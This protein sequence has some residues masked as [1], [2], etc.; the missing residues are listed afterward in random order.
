MR[1]RFLFDQANIS[2]AI[3]IETDGILCERMP[4]FEPE[5]LRS[6]IRISWGDVET[7]CL[8]SGQRYFTLRYFTYSTMFC[9]SSE[10][11]LW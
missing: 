4:S 5:T 11:L 9:G 3:G 7:F 1:G 6:E 2:D 10:I 8:M